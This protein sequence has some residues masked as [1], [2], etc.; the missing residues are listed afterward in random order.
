[1]L[2][3]SDIHF[4]TTD[5]EFLDLA[6]VFGEKHMP[7][8]KRNVLLLGDVVNFDAL[9]IYPH[10]SP[11]YS[12]S[13]EL[14]IAEAFL[15]R[16]TKTFDNILY[17][18]GNHEDRLRKS[19]DPVFYGHRF[20]RLLVDDIASAEGKIQVSMAT[21]AQVVGSSAVW[22]A[23][24]QKNYS[25]TQIAV[26]S[27]LAQKYSSNIIA[28][29]QHFVGIFRAPYGDYTIINSGGLF[30]ARKMAYV[31][32]VDNTSPQMANGFVFVDA[33][34]AGHLLTPYDS[35][36]SWALWGMTQEFAQFRKSRAKKRQS[37]SF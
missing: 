6:L 24:H 31:S 11:P 9:S 13:L 8:G 2:V 5:Y 25:R 7:S 34:G 19:L 36:T 30:D 27:A 4:P 21:R 22:R 17:V 1:V 29:H 20:M 26:G 3:L 33:E 15:V 23:T 37:K 10:V 18:Q 16:L 28:A 32:R 12:L 35:M 14:D